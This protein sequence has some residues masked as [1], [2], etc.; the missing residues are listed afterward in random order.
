MHSRVSYLLVKGRKAY[1]KALKLVAKTY[2][3]AMNII[4][5]MHD[6]YAYEKGQMALH[7]TKLS[8]LM[9]FGVAG[10][11]VA[12]DS[13]SAI[14]Y[15]KVKPIRDENG[16]AVD[17]EI[18]G[19]FPK[20][21]NDDDKVDLLGKELLEEFYNDLKEYKLYNHYILNI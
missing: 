6:K 3:D 1:S 20:Y 4:H 8:R 17:F 10:F 7:D 2:V 11:S 12:T 13:L 18:T 16:I 5:Y 15:A 9:A 21:G 19:D 14:K